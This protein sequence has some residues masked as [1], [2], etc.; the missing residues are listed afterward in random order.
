DEMMRELM[1]HDLEIT[2]SLERFL[3]HLDDAH[4]KLM[5][6]YKPIDVDKLR[7]ELAE[8]VIL[9]KEREMITSLRQASLKKTYSR[10]SKEIEE[11]IRL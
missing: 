6:S 5:A 4:D 9:F 1:K 11:K 2:E 3:E 7:H 10:M 8:I